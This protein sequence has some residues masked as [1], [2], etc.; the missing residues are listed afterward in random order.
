MGRNYIYSEE[1]RTEAINRILAG[2]TSLDISKQ[3]KIPVGTISNWTSKF[4]AEK[5]LSTLNNKVIQVEFS[6]YDRGILHRK[7]LLDFWNHTMC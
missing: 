7:L 1:I 2:E 6:P 3:L 4:F 5:Q